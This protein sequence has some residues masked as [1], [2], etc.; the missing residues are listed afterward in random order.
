MLIVY[1]LGA[2]LLL[3]FLILAIRTFGKAPGVDPS[4]VPMEELPEET[5]SSAPE[6]TLPPLTE[7]EPTITE[8]LPE[9]TS[10]ETMDENAARESS[11]A[12][13]LYDEWAKSQSSAV[14]ESETASETETVPDTTLDIT[15]EASD[16]L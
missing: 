1:A 2:V 9:E 16:E 13:S 4:T 12:Q 14:A 15:K 10:E 5:V 7:P 11:I 3:L 8:T 6:E